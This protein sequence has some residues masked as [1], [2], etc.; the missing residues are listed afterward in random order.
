MATTVVND[1]RDFLLTARLMI[2]L[3]IIITMSMSD[4]RVFFIKLHYN[5]TDF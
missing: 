3:I 1:G 5:S 2:A 4:H